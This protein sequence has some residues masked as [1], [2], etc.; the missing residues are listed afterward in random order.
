MQEEQTKKC[1]FCAEEINVEAVKCKHCGEMID[2]KKIDEKKK[3][4]ERKKNFAGIGCLVITILFVVIVF[5][6]DNLSNNSVNTAN[7]SKK[8][9]SVGENGILNNND[10]PKNCDGVAIIAFTEEA[11]D[12][13]TNASIADDKYGWNKVFNDGRATT[14]PN[15][16]KV[17]V[18]DVKLLRTKV[19]LIDDPS[20]TGWIAYEFVV[21]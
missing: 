10:D 14:V 3:G 5:S 7:N 12:E 19:R 8:I 4:K 13:I 18:I 9:L 20:V 11:F 2:E 15:C 17:K 1:P 16:T 6:G 21:H